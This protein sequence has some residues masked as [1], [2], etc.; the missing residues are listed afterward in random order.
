MIG[1]FATKHDHAP[2]R[3]GS[4]MNAKFNDITHEGKI[5]G[6]T[7]RAYGIWPATGGI[8]WNKIEVLAPD[9]TRMPH[10]N[11]IYS[12]TFHTIVDANLA[13]EARV[14]ER[15]AAIDRHAA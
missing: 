7:F 13:V 14:R 15:L 11:G 3:P 9:G 1:R 4:S 10:N 12:T 2:T 5:D 6:H 8:S